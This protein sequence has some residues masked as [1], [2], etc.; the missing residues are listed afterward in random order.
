MHFSPSARWELYVISL[1]VVRM[2]ARDAR[3]A[4]LEQLDRE[5]AIALDEQRRRGERRAA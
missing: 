5:K 3:I 4:R 1:L 2:Q